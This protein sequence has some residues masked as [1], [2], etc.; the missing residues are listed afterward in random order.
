M[1]RLTPLYLM[2]A[3]LMATPAAAQTAPEA[4]AEGREGSRQVSSAKARVVL[5]GAISLVGGSVDADKIGAT[6][7]LSEKF[8]SV[9]DRRSPRQARLIS[10]NFY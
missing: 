8:E 9:G 10:Y 3:A 2:L 7:Y 4:A 5:K 1:V 6:Y